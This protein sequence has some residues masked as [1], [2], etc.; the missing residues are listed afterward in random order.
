MYRFK[1]VETQDELEQ[2]FRLNHR[3]FASEL[4]QHRE[5]EEGLLVDKF[6]SKNTYLVALSDDRVVGMLS[7][8]SE[9]PYSVESRLSDRRLLEPFG[10][11]AEVRLLAVEPEHRTGMVITGLFMLMFQ[12]VHEFDSV[13]ISGIVEQVAMYRK[14]GF[15]DLGPPVKEGEAFFI[16]MAVTIEQL[17]QHAPR[18]RSRLARWDMLEYFPGMEK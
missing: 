14:F 12:E 2:V 7:V 15:R 13:V 16:P 4:G 1:R 3:V 11:C 6:H 10:R 9:A 5:R 17:R 8:H 18:W